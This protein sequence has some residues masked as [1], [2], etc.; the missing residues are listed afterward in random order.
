MTMLTRLI[1]ALL[2]NVSRSAAPIVVA[3]LGMAVAG[4]AVGPDFEAPKPPSVTRY[5]SPGE[6]TAP[7]ADATNAVPTQ[8]IAIGDRVAANWWTLFRS[9]KLDL[10]VKQAVEGSRTLESAKAKL[11]QAREAVA[12]AASALYPQIGLDANVSEQKQSAA[13][14]G[15]TPAEAPLP[16]SFNLFQ[17]GPTASYT[18]DLFGQTHRRIEQEVALA[19]YQSDQLDA[20]YLA[21]TGNTV[22]QA[23]QA[24]AVRSQLKALNDILAID[25]QNVEFVRKQRQAGT[26]PD[27][28]VIVAESQ[29]AADET[30]QPGLEQQLSVA[31]HALAVLIGR[32]PGNWSPPD[33]DLAAFTLPRRLPVSIPSELVHQ[34]PDIQAA[35][36]QLHAASAQ[37]GIATAQLYPSITLSAGVSASSL[38]GGELF[39]P[40]GLV[41]SVA[42]GLTQPIFDGGMRE[43]ERRAALAAFK[44]AAADY[45]QTVLRAFGQVADILQALTHDTNLLA[46][47]R[48]ALSMASEAVRLQRINY[49]SGGSGIIGLLDAQRQYQQA[50]LGYVRAEAQRYQ[51]TVQLLVAMGGGWWDQKL[52]SADGGGKSGPQ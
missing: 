11:E 14:F 5:T 31:R 37:I 32:A 39:S 1:P 23:L 42:A 15:L 2:R 24:A 40:G 27:S 36:A 43:A 45:Q 52:A 46:A 30:I 38:N 18:P 21:L 16:S 22:S 12:V 44:Q 33:F 51:D 49:G 41:W 3:A 4:C 8:A 34:R 19:E 35:E 29:L 20:A 10:L 50:Q 47:Q 6:A 7:G 13:T 28:D 25:R 48:R 26:V 9:S 17:V